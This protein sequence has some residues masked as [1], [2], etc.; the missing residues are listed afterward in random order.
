MR[1]QIHLFSRSRLFFSILLLAIA[2]TLLLI[3]APDLPRAQAQGPVEFGPFDSPSA[4][5]EG[6]LLRQEGQLPTPPTKQ[7][8]AGKLLSGPKVPGADVRVNDPTDDTP[9]NTTQSE[10]TLAVRGSTVCAGYNN[11]GPGGFS[12]LSRSAN[13]GLTWTDLGGVGQSGDPVIAVD[14]GTGT[15]FYAEI[16]TIGGNPAIGVARSTDD[17]LTFGTPVN[18]SPGAS[19]IATTTLNDKPWVAVDNTGGANDGNIYVCWTRFDSAPASELRFSRST[20]GG[21][22]YVNEQILQPNG[23]GPF[24]CSV[25]VSPNGQVNV[26]WA[27]RAGATINDIRFRR[28]ND[29]GITFAAP[30]SVSTGNRHPGI[31]TIVACGTNNNRPTLTG[32]IRMLHQSWM[33]VDT[34]GGPFNGNIY[35]AW[36]SDPVGIPDNSDVFFRRSTD[37]GVTWSASI[38]LGAGGGATD[39][40]EPHLAVGGN[41]VVSMAWYD[42]RNDVAN[43][44]LVD[45]YKTFSTDGGLTIGPLVRVTDVNFGVPQLNP[46][47]DPGITRCY[48]GEYIAVAA[49]ASRFYYLWGDNRDTLVTTNWPAGRPDPNVYFE[50]ESIPGT[51]ADLQVTKT[52]DDDPVIAGNNETYHITVTNYGPDAANNVSLTDALPANTTF[53][54]LSSPGGWSCSTPAVGANGNVSCSIDPLAASASAAFTLVVNV[55]ASTPDGTNLCNTANVSSTT[56][57]PGPSANSSQV[58][59]NVIAQ[60]DLATTKTHDVTGYAGAGQVT[61]HVTVTNNGPSDAQN[62][63]VTDALDITQT[64]FVSATPDGGG[65]CNFTSPNVT[66]SWTTLAAGAAVHLDIVADLLPNALNLCNTASASSDTTDPVPG[67]NTSAADCFAVPTLADVSI[68]KKAQVVATGR[69]IRYTLTIHNAGPSYAQKVKV[70]DILAGT[71]SLESVTTTQGTCTKKQTVVCKLGVLTFKDVIIVI[72]VNVNTAVTGVDNV[73][74]ARSVKGVNPRTPDPDLTNNKSKIHVVLGGE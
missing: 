2:G 69:I 57:D 22:T 68:V 3:G 39:Q 45:V 18:A 74:T 23:T 64:D 72:Q 26:A 65:N 73:A 61:W 8:V 20:D 31:D 11:S 55:S 15:F 40:F 60:A 25:A 34:T 30:V 28:S 10:T 19:A 29:G 54:S 50:Y 21:A 1:G 36:A 37:G 12:G 48:M 47:F 49:D 71:T 59:V 67:N 4:A 24:G 17:C 44:T 53:V 35:V 6:Y 14:Q 27:D 9:E 33:A 63:V 51:G 32:N 46:N 41:G 66:C 58:C 42:R 56:A 5:G 62:V 13:S 7:K 43:N 70:K 16:A 52:A 38:Q